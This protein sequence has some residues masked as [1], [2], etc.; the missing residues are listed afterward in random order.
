MKPVIEMHTHTRISSCCHDDNACLA[1]YI[2]KAAQIGV[3]VLGISDHCWDHPRMPGASPWYQKQDVAW[4][5][6]IRKEL[7]IDTKGIKLFIGLES[8]YCGMS[9]TMGMSA[10]A[11][12]GFDYVLIPHSHVHM[13]DFVMPRDPMYQTTAKEV[14]KR[15]RAAF[16]EVS[17]RQIEKW[18]NMN[19]AVDLEAVMGG[20]PEPDLGYVA[21]FMC[22]SFVGLLNNAQMQKIKDTVPT[23]VAHPFLA[24]GYTREQNQQM[25]AM[26]P[27]ERFQ[28]MFTLMAQKGI[29]YDISVYNFRYEDVDNCQM[30]RIARIARD[31]GVKFTFGTD[32]HSVAGVGGAVRSAEIFNALP[33]TVDDL[34][35]MIQNY[36]K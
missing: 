34:H 20:K 9:D 4:V 17:D 5:D 13:K 12:A 22:Q 25:I 15:M 24:V 33:L 14:E 8:E 7:P 27:D 32:A 26:I 36:V 1:T 11:A 21:E 3:Q 29:G 6:Q 28:E 16:P 31:C 23:F 19:R 35:P 30:C 2:D 10:E 18:M